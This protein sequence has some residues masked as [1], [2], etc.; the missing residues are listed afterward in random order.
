MKVKMTRTE[1]ALRKAQKAAKVAYKLGKAPTLYEFT[2]PVELMTKEERFQWELEKFFEDIKGTQYYDEIMSTCEWLLN[3]EETW[4]SESTTGRELAQW[5][6]DEYYRGA[7]CKTVAGIPELKSRVEYTREV[8]QMMGLSCLAESA[9]TFLEAASIELG[10]LLTEVEVDTHIQVYALFVAQGVAPAYSYLDFP[11]IWKEAGYSYNMYDYMRA[12]GEYRKWAVSERPELEE[13]DKDFIGATHSIMDFVHGFSIEWDKMIT[14]IDR[15]PLQEA[16]KFALEGKFRMLKKHSYIA[17][18]VL[19]AY[20]LAGY[21]P[22]CEYFECHRNRNAAEACAKVLKAGVKV[23]VKGLKQALNIKGKIHHEQWPDVLGYILLGVSGIGLSSSTHLENATNFR[24][25]PEH[26]KKLVAQND[27]A[28]HWCFFTNLDIDW[29]VSKNSAKNCIIKSISQGFGCTEEQA[30]SLFETPTAVKAIAF[31]NKVGPAVEEHTMPLTEDVVDEEGYKVS[32]MPKRDIRNLY[33]GELTA[34][35]QK[36]GGVGE[37]VCIQ[38]WK[39]KHSANYVLTTASGTILGHFWL[40]ETVDGGYVID[41]V[42]ARQSLDVEK[43]I[44]LVKSWVST[45]RPNRKLY[46]S[47]CYFG[48]TQKVIATLRKGFSLLA[49][50][51]P[52]PA[53]KPEGHYKYRDS[54]HGVF[55]IN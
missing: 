23:N 40:Y 54:R 35:C 33:I 16:K 51:E 22:T 10:Y 26:M 29:T 48:I 42:E 52:A 43:L 38:G 34:C 5:V 7:S 9:R 6:F 27:R 28:I 39:D 2:N 21:I 41:S 1:R 36:L 3:D 53:F 24:V 15:L 47:N 46:I 14:R 20:G 8:A 45:V 17:K 12:T 44:S 55:S 30:S 11:A 13:G 50:A 37:D 25:I 31:V 49:E 32:L 4:V 19:E 18:D